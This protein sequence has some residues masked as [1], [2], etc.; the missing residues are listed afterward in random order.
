[1]RPFFL[2]LLTVLGLW[3]CS[4]MQESEFPDHPVA[5]Q[6]PQNKMVVLQKMAALLPERYMNEMTK[7]GRTSQKI[8]ADVASMVI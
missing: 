6:I 7:T 3:S 5:L 1:M 4:H 8:V 2:L